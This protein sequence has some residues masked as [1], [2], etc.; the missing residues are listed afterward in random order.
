MS[1]ILNLL[2]VNKTTA[3]RLS[4]LIFML[5]HLPMQI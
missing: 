3:K 4:L 2:K 5:N 1:P